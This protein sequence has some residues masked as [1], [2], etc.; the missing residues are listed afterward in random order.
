MV[1]A[2]IGI[3]LGGVLLFVGD[4]VFDILEKK[5][6]LT[7]NSSFKRCL[8]LIVSITLHNIP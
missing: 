8:M 6:N 7:K 2:A 1:V 4:K 3:L 5:K